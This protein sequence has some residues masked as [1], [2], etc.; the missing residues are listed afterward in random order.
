MASPSSPFP[1]LK[2]TGD[3]KHDMELYVEDLIDGC[4]MH[5]NWYDPVKETEAATWIKPDK[6]IACLGASLHVSSCEIDMQV[7]F[8][9]D[10]RESRVK[11]DLVVAALRDSYGAGI[12]VSGERQKFLG[13][14]QEESEPIVY[15]ETR[16]C[17]H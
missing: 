16:I 13:F 14:I 12:G 3:N 17:D 15:W 8:G 11:P 6:A 4:V 9:A 5:Q 1:S 7:K 10:R 2:T